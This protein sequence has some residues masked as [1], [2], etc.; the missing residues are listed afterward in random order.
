M[1]M[2]VGNKKGP[3]A[4]INVTPLVDIVLVLLIIFMVITP[5]LERGAEV[6]LPPADHSENK[7]NAEDDTIVSVRPDGALW[8]NEDAVSEEDL[9]TRLE[10]LLTEDPMRPLLIKADV[11]TRYADVRKVMTLCEE[12]GAK[13][14]GLMT[15]KNQLP[16][17]KKEG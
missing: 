17:T 10:A 6:K 16:S 9:R 13:S 11:M 5:M 15:D 2:S 7:E 12:L 8:F 14:V 4:D 1:G 3:Q